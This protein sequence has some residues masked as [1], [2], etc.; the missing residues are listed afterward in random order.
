MKHLLAH[1]MPQ[2]AR[3]K[4][5]M[6]FMLVSLL[7]TVAYSLYAWNMQT[8]AVR[9]AIDARLITAAAAM[10]KIIGHDY[11]RS[12][13]SAESISAEQ[14]LSISQLLSDYGHKVG[15]HHLYV[16]TQQNGQVRFLA[17]SA[18]NRADTRGQYFQ[19][20]ATPPAALLEAFQS[21]DP[22]FADYRERDG[23]LFRSVFLPM[24]REDSSVVVL[25][26]DIDRDYLANLL[27]EALVRSFIIGMLSL[28]IGLLG[29]LILGRL[30]AAPVVKLADVADRIARG[31]YRARV[32]V[33]GNDE[34]ARLG[35][36]FNAMSVAISERESEITR[37]AYID[38]LTELPNRVRL[39]ELINALIYRAQQAKE[40]VAVVMIDIDRFKYIN[41]FLG[42]NVGDAA[43]KN[44]ALRLSEMLGKTGHLG[45][46]SGDEFVLVLPGIDRNNIDDTVYRLHT[47]L[48]PPLA[49]SGQS[50]DIAGS[51][52]ASFYPQHGT[53]GNTLLRQ[54]E[55]AMYMAKRVHAPYMIYDARQEESRKDQL[56]LLGELK[57]AIEENQL[58]AFYQPKVGLQDGF[59]VGVE[60]LV[61]WRH[62]E[63]GWIPPNQFIPFAEQTGRIRGL[64]L[65]MLREC[66]QQSC[67]WREVGILMKISIN[68][69]INDMEDPAFVGMVREILVDTK[70][71]AADL[72]LE[73]TE[74]AV[75][76]EPERVMDALFTFRELGFKLSID[77]F[78]TGY[79]SLA[80]LSRL[81]VNELKIDRSFMMHLNE[82]DG[83]QIV[84]AIV[85]LGHILKLEVV[86]EG[87]EN[88]EVWN[89]LSSLGCD[90]V[91]GFLVAKPM[92]A[93]ELTPWHIDHRGRW[94]LPG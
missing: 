42:Y 57:V 12:A 67:E 94:T 28:A 23:G 56:S 52:G 93:I 63:R 41:D 8:V 18:A 78:G 92:P 89:I 81:P 43:L 54:A 13:K 27:D 62:P 86:A 72:C 70:A 20:Y 29:S 34:L 58:V 71:E 61:R 44:I 22:R 49:I 90:A 74:S 55:S 77:D 24:T 45:R 19:P 76:G 88:A 32:S 36:A 1:L 16:M 40:P 26:A 46:F 83:I 75:M 7:A 65:W 82:T 21:G 33:E 79:S 2:T 51:I 31:D 66:M 17:N 35:R 87:V 15:L 53:S 84:R 25:G 64:T 60:A 68:V 85:Q 73:I 39:V 9:S 6:V 69:S 80:Y 59:I 50:I 11:L 91:Q 38:P 14:Y 48:E 4:I 37:Q 3:L 10:S 30:L 47:V 5:Q